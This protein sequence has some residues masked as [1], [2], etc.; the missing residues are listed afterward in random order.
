M[1]VQPESPWQAGQQVTHLGWV[2]AGEA[3]TVWVA[4]GLD[5]LRL[6][7]LGSSGPYGYPIE[8]DAVRL[9][10]CVGA[11]GRKV[12]ACALRDC[13]APVSLSLVL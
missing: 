7:L 3:L 1:Y 10:E 5:L 12:G 9:L 2:L 4:C 8:D 13:V 6:E 11:S